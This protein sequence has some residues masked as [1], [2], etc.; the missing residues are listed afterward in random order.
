MM[1]LLNYSTTVA[2]EVTASQIVALLVRKGA[3]NIL[4]D[5]DGNGSVTSIKW[6]VEGKYGPLGF[7]LPVNVDAVFD[8]LTKERRLTTDPVRRRQQAAM[9]AWRILKDWVEA[10]M[11]LLETG[12]VE[13]E[14]IFL[15]YMLNGSERVYQ[16]LAAGGF[17]GLPMLGAG[18]PEHWS[19]PGGGSVRQV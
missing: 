12:M 4:L 16:Q 1:P 7:G 2:A 5:Y 13:L 3:R 15:P 18:G 8:I 17:K 11:A 6:R 10:Q 19:C 9:V 14:E